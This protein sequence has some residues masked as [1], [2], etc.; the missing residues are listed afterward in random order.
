MNKVNAAN[1]IKNPFQEIEKKMGSF[2]RKEV[3]FK[4]SFMKIKDIPK[5]II[6]ELLELIESN[7]GNYFKSSKLGWNERK[8][9][10]DL[11]S[12]N[13]CYL[14]IKDED[15]LA[16]FSMFKFEMDFD[17]AVLYCYELQI[18]EEY[19]G[20]GLGRHLMRCMEELAKIH[21]MECIVLT[22][23]AN[24]EEAMRFYE[25]CGFILDKTDPQVKDYK[26]LSKATTK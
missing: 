10:R 16:G 5:E 7:V 22:A 26:I 19:Q 25:N 4:I 12:K 11:K 6:N 8:K 1:S 13:A 9:M 3:S 23:L 17:R 14:I 18:K 21:D 24:N 20:K 15:L 2:N